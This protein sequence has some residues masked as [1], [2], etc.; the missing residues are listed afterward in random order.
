MASL[1]LEK[2]QK[3]V[4]EIKEALENL[5]VPKHLDSM[6][7]KIG[8]IERNSAY[9]RESMHICYAVSFLTLFVFV[10]LICGIIYILWKLNYLKFLLRQNVYGRFKKPRACYA[11]YRPWRGKKFRDVEHHKGHFSD[12]GCTAAEMYTVP[13]PNDVSDL[14]STD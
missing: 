8:L 9:T 2:I 14:S 6:G 12:P 7:K 4:D 10:V 1:D 3:D 5:Y 13:M 11:C